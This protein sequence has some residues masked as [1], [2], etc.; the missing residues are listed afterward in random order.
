S[1]PP[2][3]LNSD[4]SRT[5][6]FIYRGDGSYI[7]G[8][9]GLASAEELNR[10]WFGIPTGQSPPSQVFIRLIDRQ[11]DITYTSNT[12]E[13]NQPPSDRDGDGVPDN[14]DACPDVFGDAAHNGCPPPPPPSPTCP[15]TTTF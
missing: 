1:L 13:L 6:V 11:C 10:I 14:V 15:A 3:G 12:I 2:C 7:Y 9:C 5:W 4:A 8:F